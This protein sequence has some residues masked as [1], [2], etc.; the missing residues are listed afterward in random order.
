MV[1]E[2]PWGMLQKDDET[3][4]MELIKVFVSQLDGNIERMEKDG[5]FFE[6]VFPKTEQKVK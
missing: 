3:L 6:I 1:L 4:G 5:T 2:C